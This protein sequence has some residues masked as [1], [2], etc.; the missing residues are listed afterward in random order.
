MSNNN[1]GNTQNVKRKPV[2]LMSMGAQERKGERKEVRD[3]TVKLET[4]KKGES[5]PQR[6]YLR[7]GEVYEN[8]S[9]FDHIQAKVDMDAN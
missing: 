6:S 9:A 3:T 2:V 1:T 4:Q 5:A 7:Q 8:D